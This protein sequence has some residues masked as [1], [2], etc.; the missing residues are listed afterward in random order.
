[1]PRQEGEGHDWNSQHQADK[2]QCRSRMRA[3]VNFPFNRHCEH[4]PAD[5][6]EQIPSHVEIERSETKCRVGIV[7]R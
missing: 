2:T 1:M 6:R 4:L 7:R 3:R 5:D